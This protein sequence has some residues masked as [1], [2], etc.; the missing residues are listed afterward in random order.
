MSNKPQKKM[1]LTD[2]GEIA[3]LD[4]LLQR[5]DAPEAQTQSQPIYCTNCG[6][7]NIHD[8]KYCRACGKALALQEVRTPPPAPPSRREPAPSAYR[9][10][11]T[12]N[13]KRKNEFMQALQ[14]NERPAAAWMAGLRLWTMLM[15]GSVLVTSFIF[16]VSWAIIPTLIAWF[17]VEAVRTER[18]LNF[19][20]FWSEILTTS[21]MAG[22]SVMSFVF[23]ESRA[24]G[25]AWAVIPIMIAW[26]LVSAVRSGTD[27]K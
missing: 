25:T 21:V 11:P 27:T 3:D 26:F 5:A 23:H 12:L 4:S 22:A 7:A 20:S 13:E 6:T 9:P 10:A 8:A 18:K 24:G 15:L 1:Q 16:D 17:L 14:T 19:A 2:D